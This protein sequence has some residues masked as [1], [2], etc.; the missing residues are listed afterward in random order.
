MVD[1]EFDKYIVCE[2]CFPVVDWQSE[3]SSC[4][5]AQSSTEKQLLK[6]TNFRKDILSI[7]HGFCAKW[8]I[9]NF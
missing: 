7:A 4:L 8:H 3:T 5:I 2:V 9:T 1:F 6:T